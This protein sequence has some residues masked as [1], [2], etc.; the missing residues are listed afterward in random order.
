M[1][2]FFVCERD[3]HILRERT[4][5]EDNLQWQAGKD[6]TEVFV[7]VFDKEQG[8]KMTQSKKTCKEDDTGEEDSTE[9]EDNARIF[10]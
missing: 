10:F 6:E 9:E 4:G 3:K 7:L 1:I 2:Y 8:K 5:E